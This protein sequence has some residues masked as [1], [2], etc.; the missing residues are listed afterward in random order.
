MMP[1]YTDE[2]GNPVYIN[3]QT[4]ATR[5]VAGVKP[6]Q[7]PQDPLEVYQKLATIIG[8]LGKRVVA[9]EIVCWVVPAAA[10]PLRLSI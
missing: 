6:I 2:N 3:P 9:A 10:S 5:G 8:L 4:G 1:G 7:A